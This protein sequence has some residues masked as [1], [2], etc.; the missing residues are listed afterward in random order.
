MK[1]QIRCIIVDGSEPSHPSL[2]E[3]IRAFSKVQLLSVF[4]D[5][6]EALKAFDLHHPDLIFLDVNMPHLNGI[7]FIM[8][9]KN[10]L[11]SPMP[12][13]VFVSDCDNYALSG[14]E[15][16]V[17]DYL[18]K[19]VSFARFKLCMDRLFPALL[20]PASA[21]DAEFFFTEM[22]GKKIKLVYRDIYFIEAAG[23]YVVVCTSTG[24]VTLYKTMNAMSQ[25]LPEDQ[26]IRVHKSYIISVY[27][28]RE[29]MGNEIVLSFLNKIRTI[30][31]GATYKE[32]LLSRLIIV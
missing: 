23:N 25:I 11:Q 12:G 9:L 19:P 26:F 20:K 17:M 8:T 3:H 5:P 30:P 32:N 28:I 2:Q 7:E 10:K 27:P 1:S 22:D 16:G 4:S 29:L 13:F 31:I 24:N 21:T 15:Y 14:Y 18:V 6:R